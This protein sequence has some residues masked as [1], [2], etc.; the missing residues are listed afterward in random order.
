MA[1]FG[2]FLDAEVVVNGVDLSSF[3]RSVRLPEETEVLEI[4]GM[5]DTSRVKIQGYLD[6]SVEVEFYQ[7]YYT[8]EVN[9]TIDPLYRNGTT[10]FVTVMPNKT[11]GVGATNPKY[12]GYAICSQFEPIGGAHGEVL[13]SNVTFESAGAISRATS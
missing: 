11:A 10:F 12:Q 4:Q 9:A 13:M 7:S 8:A 3:V 2:R 6:W 1:K 5:G